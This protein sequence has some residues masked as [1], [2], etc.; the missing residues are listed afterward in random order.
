MHMAAKTLLTVALF[1]VG[2]APTAHAL[3]LVVDLPEPGHAVGHAAVRVRSFDADVEVIY[4]F[5]RYGR[6]WGELRMSGEGILRVWRGPRQVRQY[7]RRNRPFRKT[8]GFEIA[9]TESEERAIH[10]Y[11]EELLSQGVMVPTP[12]SRPR[13]R[14]P[15]DYD[16]VAVQ[17]MS[18]ALA[19]LKAVWPRERWEH[20]INPRFNRGKG[21]GPRLRR[22]YFARQQKLGVHDT[23]AP[24][25]VVAALLAALRSDPAV[26]SR[27]RHYSKARVVSARRRPRPM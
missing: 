18:T 15:H 20:L 26:I 12:G 14:L 2:L 11:Y 1:L 21:F 4:D 24:L 27:V 13:W 19:G 17:C 10:R 16:G 6:T 5:G 23:N 7:L 8:V 25:D 22:Y 9:V 3:E